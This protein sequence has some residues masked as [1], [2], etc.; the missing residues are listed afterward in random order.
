MQVYAGAF[1]Q[2]TEFIDASNGTDNAGMSKHRLLPC[3]A[4]NLK[5]ITTNT[6]TMLYILYIDFL[7]I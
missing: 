3:T 6:R 7:A 2:F 4:Y 5:G 1:T